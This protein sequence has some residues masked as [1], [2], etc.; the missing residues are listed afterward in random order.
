MPTAPNR[1]IPLS[2]C[3][4]LW[5]PLTHI[6]AQTQAWAPIDRRPW[7]ACQTL[8]LPMLLLNP[9]VVPSAPSSLHD[10]KS[11]QTVLIVLP[12]ETAQAFTWRGRDERGGMR[13]LCVSN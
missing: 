7:Y 9:C 13:W 2:L 1:A 6:I 10:K 3:P 4:A 11:P 12:F 8:L 5:P